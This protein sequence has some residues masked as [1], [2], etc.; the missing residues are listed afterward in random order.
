MSGPVLELTPLG[1]A[2]V[3]AMP[4]RDKVRKVRAAFRRTKRWPTSALYPDQESLDRFDREHP[5]ARDDS[6]E[7]D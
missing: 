1:A 5:E 6:R 2:I 3:E 7:S 4:D